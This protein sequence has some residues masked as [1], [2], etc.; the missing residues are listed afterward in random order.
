MNKFMLASKKLTATDRGKN[1]YDYF[2]TFLETVS[3]FPVVAQTLSTFY[4]AHLLHS[5]L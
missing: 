1:P 5:T 2:E 4:V 3:G